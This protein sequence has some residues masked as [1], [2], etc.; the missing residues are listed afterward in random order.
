[1]EK[2]IIAIGLMIIIGWLK[3]LAD[4]I[5]HSAE[6]R[7]D[8]WKAKWKTENGVVLNNGGLHH[9]WY[10]WDLLHRTTNNYREKFIFSSTLLVWL[11]DRW[12]M[13]NFVSYRI[14]DIGVACLIGNAWLLLWLPLARWAG[15][16]LTYRK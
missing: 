14:T 10:L 15:F 2:I 11:T 1:M 13:A 12:H 3:G 6:Y 7:L 8:G 16:K 5:Q 4:T 9:W